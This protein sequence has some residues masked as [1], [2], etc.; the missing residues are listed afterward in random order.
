MITELPSLPPEP[1]HFAHRL[2]SKMDHSDK[3]E[4]GSSSSDVE[5]HTSAAPV[6]VLYDPSKESVWTRV[7]L[8]W[9]SYKRAPGTTG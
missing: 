5:V 6:N 7:G 8:S 4:K 2:S 1:Q 3:A 9:E